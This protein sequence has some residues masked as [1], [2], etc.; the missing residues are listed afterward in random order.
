MGSNCAD[1]SKANLVTSSLKAIGNIGAYANGATLLACAQSAE[2]TLE[3]RVNAI[4][5]HRGFQCSKLTGLVQVLVDSSA[6]TE[7][8]IN[9]FLV[10]AKCTD[11][12]EFAA[13]FS[14][15]FTQFLETLDDV[16]VN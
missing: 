11:D 10:L 7:L 2:S 3:V 9:A 8:R 4:Q 5:A 16:Q 1:S 15:K 13:A 12:G 14:G 6:D